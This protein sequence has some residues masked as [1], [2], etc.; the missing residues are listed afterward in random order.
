M[1][2]S[3][4]GTHASL[5]AIGECHQESCFVL[6]KPAFVLTFAIAALVVRAAPARAQ[7]PK[8]LTPDDAVDLAL[9][10]TD[11]DD[12]D[13]AADALEELRAR[14]D[15]GI[16]E[17]LDAAKEYDEE[18]QAY[19]A[20]AIAELG[21][22]AVPQLIR[23]MGEEDDDVRATA[24]NALTEL[25]TDALEGLVKVFKETTNEDVRLRAAV[26]LGKLEEDGVPA[27]V[28]IVKYGPKELQP[29]A[30]ATLVDV[31]GPSIEALAQAVNT[32]NQDCRELARQGLLKI[33][34]GSVAAATSVTL[35]TQ[36]L[37]RS[38]T[39]AVRDVAVELVGKFGGEAV[40]PKVIEALCSDDEGVRR[41][42][43]ACAADLG[44]PM[45]PDLIH[46]LN[47]EDRKV[48]DA[49]CDALSAIGEP[50]AAALTKALRA[51]LPQLR[52]QAVCAL[53]N[54]KRRASVPDLAPLFDDAAENVRADARMAL[55]LITGEKIA[56]KA[57]ALAWWEK[58]AQDAPK[59]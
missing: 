43:V 40:V 22:E 58:H 15:D 33:G 36:D 44:A 59:K 6:R 19:L 42:A 9:R 32:N 21:K 7:D 46:C 24:L 20:I 11:E 26:L 17:L 29:L 8:P 50:A 13:D 51:P 10:I 3:F 4:L 27:L 23:T 56:T 28:G 49:A 31:G 16:W 55:E 2:P 34:A 12:E 53:G 57:E 45:V 54:M 1:G 38:K 5:R 35:A 30:L 18:A 52:G 47:A 14:G 39:S 48:S 25:G 37:L 41:S